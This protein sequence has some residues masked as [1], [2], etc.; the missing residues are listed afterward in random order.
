[1][2]V[3]DVTGESFLIILKESSSAFKG[4]FKPK[5]DYA[6]LA[7]LIRNILKESNIGVA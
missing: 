7:L 3:T 1:M 4:T 5:T 2:E 6:H